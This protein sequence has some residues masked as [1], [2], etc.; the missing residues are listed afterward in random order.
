MKKVLI[1][2][3]NLEI[4]RTEEVYGRG[5]SALGCKVQI[6]TWKEA[7]A[8]VSSSSLWGRA[9][10]RLAWQFLGKLANHQLLEKA[11]QFQPDLTLVISPRLVHPESI[12][13]LQQYGLVFVFYTDNPIDSHHTHTNSWVQGGFPLW[14]ATFIWS[15]EIVERLKDNGVKK[16]FFHPFCSD[17]E[18]HFP[19]RQANPL[20]D[21]AFIGNWDA[22]RKREQYL[23]AIANYRLG[24]W[25][26]NYWN[27]HCQEPSLKGL[28]QGMC[29]YQEIPKILGSAH[30]GLNILRPQNEEGHNI[31][32]YE[33]PA[34]KTLM[35][36]ERSHDLLNLFVEDKEAV[37]FSQPEELRQ[38]VDY[39]LKNPALMASIA[40]AGYQKALAN[41]ISVRVTEMATIYQKI[42]LNQDSDLLLANIQ[43]A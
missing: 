29:S 28:C 39:L 32:T 37:Y 22:S 15:Q 6:F 19:Q 25:G 42:K 20:Y 40:E 5:F 24:L 11:N 1:I 23:K 21:V 8:T 34:T 7:T 26:S 36:S 13:A 41:K 35:I 16:A 2:G 4:G 27:T 43:E 12:K 10:W 9:A 3:E 38:K 17:I 33:I 18:Y 14:D 30:M 31:R